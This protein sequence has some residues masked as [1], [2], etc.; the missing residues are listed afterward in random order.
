MK[1]TQTTDT[2]EQ[3]LEHLD[4]S[5]GLVGLWARA[6]GHS[7]KVKYWVFIYGQVD[8]EHY[9]V[10]AVAPLTGEPNVIRIVPLKQMLGWTFY[11][12]PELLHEEAEYEYN[13]GKCRYNLDIPPSDQEEAP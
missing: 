6:R 12:D 8:S 7:G 10:Q 2:D 1:D 5:P 4:V 13:H 3:Q 9:L 11:A